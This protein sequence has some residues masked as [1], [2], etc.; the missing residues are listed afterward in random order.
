MKLNMKTMTI[1]LLAALV[2]ATADET[3][4][5]TIS[6]SSEASFRI[7]FMVVYS[8]RSQT[9]VLCR[10]FNFLSGLWT[11]RSKKY[12]YHVIVSTQDGYSIEVP[13]SEM[14]PGRCDW[15]PVHI[16]YTLTS[17]S[18]PDEAV[19]LRAR[20]ALLVTE[21]EESRN[22]SHLPVT[23]LTILCNFEK[24]YSQPEHV[25]GAATITNDLKAFEL[26][27]VAKQ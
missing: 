1:I 25:V 10:D 26:N 19:Q 15:R 14:V 13:L 5:L 21:Y 18:V 7:T 9:K 6:G 3:H 2:L 27:F 23:R 22:K 20:Y 24:Y 4:G 11:G 16:M 17:S 8:A 12:R